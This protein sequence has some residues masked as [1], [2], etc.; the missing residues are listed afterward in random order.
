MAK[1][2]CRCNHTDGRHENVKDEWH[3]DGGYRGKCNHP[4][5]DCKQYNFDHERWVRADEREKV[6]KEF[7]L[8]KK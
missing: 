2:Y 6:M 7:G 5:C 8:T 4:G 1:R 3:R